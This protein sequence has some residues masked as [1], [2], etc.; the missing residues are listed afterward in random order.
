VATGNDHIEHSPERFGDLDGCHSCVLKGGS[1]LLM[2]IPADRSVMRW[3]RKGKR[4]R[5]SHC[6]FL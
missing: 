3:R 6:T 2:M 4:R 1:Y 5:E